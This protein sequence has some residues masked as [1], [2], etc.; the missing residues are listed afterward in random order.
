MLTDFLTQTL[1]QLDIPL[2]YTLTV[3]SKSGEWI[4]ISMRKL[5]DTLGMLNA[6]KQRRIEHFVQQYASDRNMMVR[7]LHHLAVPIVS[8]K[9]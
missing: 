3:R 7:C 2:D 1:Q 6:R 4:Q 9:G 8:V 5:I